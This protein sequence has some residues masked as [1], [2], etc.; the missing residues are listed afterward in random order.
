MYHALCVRS[1]LHVVVSEMSLALHVACLWLMD[2]KKAWP[3]VLDVNPSLICHFDSQDFRH[4]IQIC[5]INWLALE[6]SANQKATAGTQRTVPLTVKWVAIIE[7]E[8]CEE[9]LLLLEVSTVERDWPAQKLYCSSVS[10]P[11]GWLDAY[12]YIKQRFYHQHDCLLVSHRDISR[13]MWL[14]EAERYFWKKTG[15]RSGSAWRNEHPSHKQQK[16]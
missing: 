13:Q 3:S 9:T 5:F 4:W 10:Q 11:C 2:C 14:W 12:Q 1:M 16:W 8:R 6:H 15:R 7:P